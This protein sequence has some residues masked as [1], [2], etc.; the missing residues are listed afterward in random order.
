LLGGIT[1]FWRAYR[2]YAGILHF[3]YLTASDPNGFTCDHF[4]NVKTL[5]PDPYFADYMGNAFKPLGFT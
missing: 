1:E 4:R 3:V 5:E 2:R